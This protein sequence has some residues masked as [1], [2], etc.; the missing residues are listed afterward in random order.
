MR[1]CRALVVVLI[2]LALNVGAGLSALAQDCPQHPTA[3]LVSAAA[4]SP[5]LAEVGCCAVGLCPV[6]APTPAALVLPQ[7]PGLADSLAR[8]NLRIDGMGLATE[9][10]GHPPRQA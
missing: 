3:T 2:L 4:I 8:T 6:C 9:P 5:S 1:I 10:A 7:A